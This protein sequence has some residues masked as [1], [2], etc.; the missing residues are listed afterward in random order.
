MRP[1]AVCLRIRKPL[2]RPN[3]NG[4]RTVGDDY[5]PPE[6]PESKPLLFPALTC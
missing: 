4:G 1:S 2:N 5:Y 6:E 3:G